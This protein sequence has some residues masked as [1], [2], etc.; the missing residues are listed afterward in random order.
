MSEQ[1]SKYSDNRVDLKIVGIPKNPVVS[2]PKLDVVGGAARAYESRTYANGG[3]VV[4][5]RQRA[6][7]IAVNRFF[8]RGVDVVEVGEYSNGDYDLL[9]LIGTDGHEVR[10]NGRRIGAVDNKVGFIGSVVRRKK[11]GVMATHEQDERLVNLARAW[12]VQ[13]PENFRVFKDTTCKSGLNRAI[14][15]YRTE[16]PGS[17]LFAFGRIFQGYDGLVA[18]VMRLANH[19]EGA[20]IKLDFAPQGQV[21]AGGQG[22]LALPRGLSEDEIKNKLDGLVGSGKYGNEVPLSGVVQLMVPNP[23]ILSIS[24]GQNDKGEY[25]VY[26]AHYQTQDGNTAAGALPLPDTPYARFLMQD[27]WPELARFY[28]RQGITGRQNMNFIVIPEELHTKARYI[29]GE[30]QMPNVMPIDLNYRAIS[31]TLNAMARYEEETRRRIDFRNFCSGGIKVDPFYAANPHLLYAAAAELGLRAGVGGDFAVINMGTFE[32]DSLRIRPYFKTQV[33][34]NAVEDSDGAVRRL[35]QV[36]GVKP[37]RETVAGYR[38]LGYDCFTL[39]EAESMEEGRYAEKIYG[40]LAK[41][42]RS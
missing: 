14:D 39:E 20:Y 17:C 13:Y 29:Y 9:T 2:V 15:A 7:E 19:G 41:I 22:Q 6:A 25:V 4:V 18:E 12:G 31:G 10:V 37:D 30:P 34:V 36:V 23:D 26:E 28:R 42:V 38:R 40:N 1:V 5:S 8:R 33:L 35:E 32:Q 3:V 16:N 21:N 11:V 27:L 24:S